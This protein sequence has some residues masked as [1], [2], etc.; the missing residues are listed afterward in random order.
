MQK[1]ISLSDELFFGEKLDSSIKKVWGDLDAQFKQDLSKDL[2]VLWGVFEKLERKVNQDIKE[3]EN[4]NVS[5]A[6]RVYTLETKLKEFEEEK[7]KGF[8]SFRR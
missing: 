7:S 3:L 4:R 1:F 5:L 8:F 6:Q 2:E